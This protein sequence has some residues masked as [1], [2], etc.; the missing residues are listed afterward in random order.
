MQTIKHCY[1]SNK[2]LLSFAE[3]SNGTFF[4]LSALTE[5]FLSHNKIARIDAGHFSGL[6]ELEVL[7]LDHN[8]I[9]W[10]NDGVLSILPR[11]RVLTLHNNFLVSLN[12]DISSHTVE[13]HL[14]TIHDNRWE[15]S[16]K[17]D[18]SWIIQTVDTLNKSAVKYLNQVNLERTASV[19][20]HQNIFG[21]QPLKAQNNFL[22]FG[23]GNLP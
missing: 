11:L 3:L 7:K 14:V 4:G 12:L 19:Q 23:A 5:L 15:C 2:L 8:H 18:C 22:L 16:S 10:I 1:Y 13:M 17:S 20:G 6:S 21:C 9:E